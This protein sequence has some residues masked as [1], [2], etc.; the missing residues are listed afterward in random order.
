[1]NLDDRELAARAREGDRKAFDELVKLN[2][3][4]MFAMI[5]RM[6]GDRESALDLLQDTLFTAFKELKN[7][8]GDSQFSSWLYRIASSRTVN[9]LRRKKILSILPLGM[10]KTPEPSYNMPD[11]SSYSELNMRLAKAVE[12]L[13]PKQK[14]V[15]N[16]RF[17]DKLPFGDIAAIL[18]KSESTVKTNYQK[19]LE[20]LQ[21]QLKDFRQ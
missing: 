21:D 7:F 11:I 16:L 10:G 13:P 14:L 3:D 4:K 20:K 15:F 5:Y 2:K 17:Y 8:R 1:M 6:T 18:R 19:A 9:Y 12:S